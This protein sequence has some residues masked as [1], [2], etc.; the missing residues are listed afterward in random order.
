M[1]AKG[2]NN[3]ESAKLANVFDQFVNCRSLPSNNPSEKK[4]II[5]SL[6]LKD[7]TVGLMEFSNQ[8]V[9]KLTATTEF[10]TWALNSLTL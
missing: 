2:I 8:I 4:N 3:D 10:Q 6:H 1:I 7:F 9:T 5:R